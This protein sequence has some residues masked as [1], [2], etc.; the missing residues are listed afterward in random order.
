[1]YVRNA[2]GDGRNGQ[3]TQAGAAVAQTLMMAAPCGI[4]SSAAAQH[5]LQ[6]PP[7][8]GVS[9]AVGPQPVDWISP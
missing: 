5:A 4:Y 3:T 1:M 7:L 6:F 8:C 9:S 2:N